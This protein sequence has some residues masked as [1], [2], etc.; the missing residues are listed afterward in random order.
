MIPLVNGKSILSCTEDD[1]TVLLDNEDYRE[2]EYVDYKLNFAF[3]E[4]SKGKERDAKKA[5]FKTDI[6]SFAN[7]DGG[8][9]IFGIRD[10]N[11]CASVIEGIDIP[12]DDTDHFELARRNDLN[13]IQPKIPPL[14]FSFIRLKTGKYVLVIDVKHDSFCPYVYLEGA[15]NYRIH[16]RYGNGKRSMTY[17]KIRQMFIQS[18]SLEQFLI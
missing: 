11:G 12:N 10:K 5:E 4:M 13:G 18:L 17:S 3:L 9:I 8:C 14:Q 16:R 15:N 7:A 1:L 2:N 6:C